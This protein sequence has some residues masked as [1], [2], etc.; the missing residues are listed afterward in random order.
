MDGSK[1]AI[2]GHLKTGHF[3]RPETGVEI[4]FTAS[5]VGNVF[6]G[7]PALAVTPEASGQLDSLQY[8]QIQIA[9]LLEQLRGRGPGK[10]FRQRVPPLP[11][12]FLQLQERLHRVVPLLW[13]R[14]AVRWPTVPDPGF[15]GLA[16]LPVTCLPLRVRQ[17]LT[18]MPHRYVTERGE[19]VGRAIEAQVWRQTHRSVV[20][21]IGV[22][23]DTRWVNLRT[24]DEPFYFRPLTQSYE[25]GVTVHLRTT[26]DPAALASA[27]R[28][29]V[30][31]LEPMLP[32]SNIRTMRAQF[33]AALAQE[34]LT[35]TLVT[36]FG[37][38]ALVGVYGVIAYAVTQRTHEIGVRL[39]LGAAR[40]RIFGRIVRH[41][42][43][44]VVVGT[45]IGAAGALAVTELLSGL[46][47]G[48]SPT[49]PGTFLAVAAL[50][51]LA[52]FLACVVPA[53]QAM[54][55]DPIKALRY[56]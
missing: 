37:V 18:T 44:L 23:R 28:A 20:I 42:M 56:E 22:A 15:A 26:R 3:R 51:A 39:A 24:R 49:D 30:R 7:A 25:S 19:T 47:F 54:R 21:G 41:G 12:L 46:L 33:D 40:G 53:R 8:R 9:D 2:C 45:A 52:A 38:L 4:Y 31:R 11:V 48:V 14:S 16:P 10:R 35:A 6:A 55:V 29:T 50:F 32:V 5:S 36:I 17:C 1:P 13:P 43:A 27:V 34:R